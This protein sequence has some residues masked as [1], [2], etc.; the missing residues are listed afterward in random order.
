M[1]MIAAKVQE[2][3]N[4]RSRQAAGMAEEDAGA[5]GGVTETRSAARTTGLSA[6]DVPALRTGW[7]GGGGMHAPK[8]AL[9]LSSDDG[10]VMSSTFIKPVVISGEAAFQKCEK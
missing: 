2:S 6:Q 1:K 4:A 9:G 5:Y 10:K 8:F 7:S 3:M